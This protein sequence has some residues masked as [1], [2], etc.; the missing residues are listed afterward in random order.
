MLGQNPLVGW[1]SDL[2]SGGR[3]FD[4]RLPEGHFGVTFFV[5]FG[6]SWDVSGS[7]LGTFADGFGM[8]LEK[9]SHW[10]RKMKLFKNDRE[11]FS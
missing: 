4:S 7:G 10:G 3:G 1:S 9:M 8:V 6:M 2:E 5:N 11:Y